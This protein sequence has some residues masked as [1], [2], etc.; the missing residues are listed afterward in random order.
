MRYIFFGCFLSL[1]GIFYMLYSIEFY[2]VT[3]IIAF[4]HAFLYFGLFFIFEVVIKDDYNLISFGWIGLVSG[5][6]VGIPLS[7]LC[8]M[9]YPQVSDFV[10]SAWGGVVQVELLY[11]LITEVY[12]NL[13]IPD[14]IHFSLIF[15]SAVGFGLSV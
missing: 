13:T 3:S 6:V 14:W 10:I 4:M 5:V 12:F 15:A 11:S 8:S 9:N 2:H 1:V 7:L